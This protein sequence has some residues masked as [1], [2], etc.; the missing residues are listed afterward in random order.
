MTFEDLPKTWRGININ[1]ISKEK[2]AD[3]T[4]KYVLEFSIEN[5]KSKTEFYI[6]K[7]DDN[8]FFMNGNKYIVWYRLCRPIFSVQY[9]DNKQI[10][11]IHNILTRPDRPE[12]Y[13]ITFYIKDNEKMCEY[14]NKVYDIK[15]T[16]LH[17]LFYSYWLTNLD[18]KDLNEYIGSESDKN[19]ITLEDI[20]NIYN[21]LEN[22]PEYSTNWKDIY[23]LRII[24]L[25]DLIISTIM[26]ALPETLR[27][28]YKGEID[29]KILTRNIRSFLATD[30]PEIRI[31]LNETEIASY[32]QNNKVILPFDNYCDVEDLVPDIS[33]YKYIDLLDA[34]QSIKVGSVGAIK[35]DTIIKDRKIL[36]KLDEALTNSVLEEIYETR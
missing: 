29:S 4:D 11:Y 3:V 35:N 22:F 16:Y 34:P 31:D 24:G 27:N 32:A 19:Y 1:L 15:N 18:R 30:A 21:I 5:I 12:N 33:W 23:S 8:R 17:D 14:Q 20:N 28:F 2:V 25:E 10:A 7:L 6:P 13:D 36:I 9:I 26:L